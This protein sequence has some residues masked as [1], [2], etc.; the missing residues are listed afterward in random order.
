MQECIS[1]RSLKTAP[2]WAKALTFTSKIAI[3]QQRK[4]VLEQVAIRLSLRKKQLLVAIHVIAVA[5]WFGG[6]VGMFVLGL[7]LKHAV[8]GE[9]L[10]FT[11]QS[12]HIID[13][14]LLKY[15]A[16]LTLLTG[17]LLSVWT[18]WGLFKHYW[19]LVKFV[20]TLVTILIGIFFLNNW[21][22]DLTIS[23]ADLGDSAL[24]DQAFQNTWFSMLVTSGFNLICLVTMTFVTYLK[25]FGKIKR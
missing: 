17:I 16:L 19:I 21:L 25:P 13:E 18:Q 11:L 8:G 14:S 20:L 6:T 4:G 22:A 9:Q 3:I 15:P 10:Y 23:A 7:Y 12:M 5:L 1:G 2:G 24:Q